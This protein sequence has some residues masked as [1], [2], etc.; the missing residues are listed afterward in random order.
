MDAKIREI[1]KEGQGHRKYDNLVR[2]WKVRRKHNLNVIR[3]VADR[4][5][6]LLLVWAE[7]NP[8]SLLSKWVID[9]YY[10]DRESLRRLNLLS[11]DTVLKDN[12]EMERKGLFPKPQEV[13]QQTLG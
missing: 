6:F 1:V 2:E 4:T 11:P 7:D 5:M 3:D 13:Q 9:A 10:N 8:D 12:R